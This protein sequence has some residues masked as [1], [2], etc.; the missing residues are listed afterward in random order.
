LTCDPV[1]LSAGLAAKVTRASRARLR[2]EDPSTPT[3]TGVVVNGFTLP[4]FSY[5]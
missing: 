1:P 5:S 2:S 3:A 4:P